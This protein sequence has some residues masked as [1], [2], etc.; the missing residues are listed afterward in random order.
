MALQRVVAELRQARAFVDDDESGRPDGQPGDHRRHAPAN[1]A[2]GG[3]PVAR[4]QGP[5]HSDPK[6]ALAPLG[7]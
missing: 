2:C 5:V 7:L 6:P 1:K 4:S 3:H